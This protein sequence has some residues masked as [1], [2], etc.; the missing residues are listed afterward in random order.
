VFVLAI[1]A[2]AM[3]RAAA[4]AE[5]LDLGLRREIFV[6]HFLIAEME[7]VR[8]VPGT[9][10]DE[11]EVMRFDQ[12]WEGN[13]SIWVSVLKDGDSYRMYYRGAHAEPDGRD[14]LGSTAVTCYA[15]SRDG[16]IWTK[17]R[18]GL[19]P[20]KG[21]HANNIVL[22]PGEKQATANFAVFLDELAEIPA[23]ERYKAIGG[24]RDQGL[25]RYTSADGI[26]WRLFSGEALFRGY[27][28]DTMNVP[29][30]SPAE[31]L[32]AIYLRT[33]SE[34]GTP[35]R[36]E[37]KGLRTV[38]R[39]TSPDFV[40]WSEPAPMEFGDVPQ[41]DL[42]T[43]S[44]T[45]YYRA[46]HVLV[47]LAARFQRDRQVL[48]LAELEELQVLPGQRRGISDA[49]LMT[50]R[51]GIRYDRTF[52]Q[53]FVRPGLDRGAWSARNNYPG[54]GIVQTGPAEMSFYVSRN[55]GQ[56]R[57]HL[58]RYSLRLDGFG[59]L[60]GDYQ[61]G[62]VL[63]KAIRVSGNRLC[64][65]YSTSASGSIL[66]ELLDASGAVIA[67]YAA[68]DCDVMVGDEIDRRV[69]WRGRSDLGAFTGKPIR[70]RFHLQDANIFALQF[71]R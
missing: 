56:P 30:W 16:V 26:H 64:L 50:S 17:P 2:T 25:F 55:Y 29:V 28:L 18:L 43:N 58:R 6:D 71:V 39:S 48:S 7:N 60:Q 41:E 22:A 44:T 19:H 3:I 5:V 12:P 15:E 46:P 9:P 11:G 63:T 13:V 40:N 69:T 47:A 65:N 42:Y 1:T 20:F 66:V 51:G 70:V 37:F 35:A 33:W 14:K 23:T 27:A 45:P 53:S 67:G 38:S 52:M 21:D 8:L 57:N 32:Y 68:E 31:Q 54:L 62:S 49:V 59:S 36:P 61:G 24:K 10:A 34:G 4:A